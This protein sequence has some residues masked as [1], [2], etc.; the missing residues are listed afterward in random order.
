LE[1]NVDDNIEELKNQSEDVKAAYVQDADEIYSRLT[2]MGYDNTTQAHGAVVSALQSGN[3]RQAEQIVSRAE[4]A[5]E[6]L[7]RSKVRE[8]EAAR[9]LGRPVRRNN[10]SEPVE[11]PMRQAEKMFA[12]GDM[13][14]QQ[15]TDAKKKYGR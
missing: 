3:L 13:T 8:E 11:N 1:N 15:F 6:A 7:L 9:L 12:D 2:S 14:L 10:P 5:N 4:G